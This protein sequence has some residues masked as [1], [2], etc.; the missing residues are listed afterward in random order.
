[1]N[2]VTNK[3]SPART[4]AW[5]LKREYWEHRGGF[6]WAQFITGGIAVFFALL[7]AVIGAISARRNMVGDSIAMAI[8]RRSGMRTLRPPG[9]ARPITPGCWLATIAMRTRCRT[10]IG[11]AFGLGRG[12]EAQPKQLVT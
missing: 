7:G 2:A 12:L 1:M 5:L 9:L 8:G 10:C 3:A 4:F 6:V 11:F